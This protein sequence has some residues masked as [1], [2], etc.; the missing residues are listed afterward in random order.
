MQKF[1]YQESEMSFLGEIKTFF[2]IFKELSF[3]EK[4]QNIKSKLRTR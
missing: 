3:G 2:I 1:E 4:K